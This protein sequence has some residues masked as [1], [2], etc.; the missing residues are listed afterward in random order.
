MQEAF[1]L[2]HANVLGAL[3]DFEYSEVEA[4]DCLHSRSCL[5]N[6]QMLSEA[7]I[8]CSDRSLLVISEAY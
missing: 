4:K 5:R 1:T 2:S 3:E 6:I 7:M 8:R